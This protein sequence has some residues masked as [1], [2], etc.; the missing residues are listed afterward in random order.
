[1]LVGQKM[2]KVS[3]LNVLAYVIAKDELPFTKYEATKKLMTDL[4]TFDKKN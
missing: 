1:M 2:A 4:S 3:K